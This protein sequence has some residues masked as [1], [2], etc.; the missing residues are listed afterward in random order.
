MLTNKEV[1]K[2]ILD[3]RIFKVKV[4]KSLFEINKQFNQK[5]IYGRVPQLPLF[6]IKKEKQ[7]ILIEDL[8]L[9]QILD[10]NFK[11]KIKNN[12]HM[13]KQDDFQKSYLSQIR[14]AIEYKMAK[15]I[16]I[17][18]SLNFDKTMSFIDLETK[19]KVRSKIALKTYLDFIRIKREKRQNLLEM[20]AG[21][22]SKKYEDYSI[23]ME[24]VWKKKLN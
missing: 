11:S 22:D 7:L 5:K 2:E 15:Y 8:D 10:P 20:R 14:N 23:Y 24:M 17:G 4:Q 3:K 21:V 6:D 19:L 12:I 1:N 13:L 16:Q 18:T 9:M